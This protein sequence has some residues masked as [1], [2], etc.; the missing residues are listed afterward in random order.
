MKFGKHRITF[1][2]S[3]LIEDLIKLY[4]SFE[5]LIPPKS[6]KVLLLLVQVS[7]DKAHFTPRLR[8]CHHKGHSFPVALYWNS[9][10]CSHN[11]IISFNNLLF[12]C[13][14]KNILVS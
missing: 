11:K 3:F 8:E 2:N 7:Q 10:T 1:V 5:S 6:R 4:L 13:F 12:Y 14:I 9:F